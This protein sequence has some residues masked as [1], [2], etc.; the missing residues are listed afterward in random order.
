MSREIEI[1]VKLFGHLL[2]KELNDL[3]RIASFL[4]HSYSKYEKTFTDSK[5]VFESPE[6]GVKPVQK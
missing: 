6:Y 5:S 1:F 2:L 4:L 3:Q